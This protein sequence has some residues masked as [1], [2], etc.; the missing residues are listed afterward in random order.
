MK[1]INFF[2]FIYFRLYR[3]SKLVKTWSP[4]VTAAI[5]FFL[6]ILFFVIRIIIIFEPKFFLIFVEISFQSYKIIYYLVGIFIGVL[7]CIYFIRNKKYLKIEEEYT[8]I[9]KKI[10]RI[11]DISLIIYFIGIFLSFFLQEYK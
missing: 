5:F 9:N 1:K 4:D 8:N 6:A 10:K 3:F 11:I 2:H 7:I